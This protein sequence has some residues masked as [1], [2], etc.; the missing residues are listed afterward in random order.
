MQSININILPNPIFIYDADWNIHNA[1]NVAITAL[2]FSD[3]SELSGKNILS[4]LPKIEYSKIKKI[5]KELNDKNS[6]SIETS[7][8]HL[9]VKSSLLKCTASFQRISGYSKKSEATFIESAIIKESIPNSP[10]EDYKTPDYFNILSSNIPGIEMFL[11]DKNLQI[12]CSLGKTSLK[13]EHTNVSVGKKYLHNYFSLEVLKILNPLL[14]IAFGSTPVSGEF[15]LNREYFS[16]R[17]IPL[18]NKQETNQCVIILQN[19]TSTKLTEQKLKTSKEEAE[20]ANRAKDNFVAKISHEIRAPLNAIMGFS[21]QLQQTKLTKKQENYLN[22]VS[23]SSQHL[24]SIIDDIL[25]LSKIES[26]QIEL[27]EIPFNVSSI[28]KTVNQILEVKYKEKN[29]RFYTSVDSFVDGTLIGDPAKLRQVLIN[30]ADNAIK[31]THKGSV[32]IKC[33]LSKQLKKQKKLRFEVSDTG[34]GITKDELKRIFK[35]FKQVDNIYDRNY[36]GCGLG[37]AISKDLIEVMGGK[38]K[39]ES[40]PGIGST[41]SFELCFKEINEEKDDSIVHNFE[42]ISLKHLNVL[43][44]DDDPVSRMLGNIILKKHKI[45]VDFAQ[46]GR[47]A[48]NLYHPGRYNFV[49][50]D[51]NM[52]HMNGVEVVKHIRKTEEKANSFYKA[53]VI[54]MTA[55]SIKKQILYYLRSGM[56]SVITKPYKEETILKKI[57]KYSDNDI[58]K[59]NLTETNIEQKSN[60]QSFNLDE[61]L[62]IT[63][64]DSEFTLQML[65]AFIENGN[66]LINKMQKELSAENYFE[67]GKAAHRLKPSMEQLG[68]N[69]AGELLALVDHK[70]SINKNKDKDSKLVKTTIIEAKAGVETIKKIAAEIKQRNT[71]T[72]TNTNE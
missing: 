49:F 52:P 68:I 63:K 3:I 56:D 62:D 37:L 6:I 12:L 19:I 9:Y 46:S 5:Q 50:L 13:T 35:P 2:G 20:K 66:Y 14:K 16:V 10:Y 57:I 55:N 26:Q 17:L 30:F 72:Q 8:D 59:L 44:V 24:L 1:N 7:L 36:T 60:E 28:V 53:K 34:I 4:L 32:T 40:K 45:K 48:I 11:V 33:T 18:N 58:K 31:F 42:N 38:L 43:F 23:N 39:V 67:I 69:K 41:F 22:I 51:I 71:L 25:V 64:G 70:Y 15:L 47:E 21:E 27:E 61:L 29:L 54:A 65:N